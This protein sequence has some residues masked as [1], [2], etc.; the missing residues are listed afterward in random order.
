MTH[1][2]LLY[3]EIIHAM[4]PHRE[5]L[6]IDCTLGAGG[7]AWGILQASSPDGQLLGLDLDPQALELAKEKLAEYGERALLVR[8]SYTTLLKQ[9]EALKWQQGGGIPLD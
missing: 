3:N 2:P 8:A 1:L 4:Q 6:Y 9:L 7:H 5:G